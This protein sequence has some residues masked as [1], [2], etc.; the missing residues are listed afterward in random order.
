MER[1]SI[2]RCQFIKGQ[3]KGCHSTAATRRGWKFVSSMSQKHYTA[4][5]RNIRF[6]TRVVNVVIWEAGGMMSKLSL[7]SIFIIAAKHVELHWCVIFFVLNLDTVIS[8]HC[9]VWSKC[10][11]AAVAFCYLFIVTRI[12]WFH[13]TP[14]SSRSRSPLLLVEN[15]RVPYKKNKNIIYRHSF[16]SSRHDATNKNHLLESLSTDMFRFFVN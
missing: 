3:M 13:F 14:S 7:H 9:H 16:G 8:C 11:I 10:D 2:N 1:F 5:W 4:P 6:F 15:E 12:C